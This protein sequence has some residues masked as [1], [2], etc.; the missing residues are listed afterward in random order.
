[1]ALSAIS[2]STIRR[3]TRAAPQAVSVACASCT[4]HREALSRKRSAIASSTRRFS[5][6][7]LQVA[8]GVRAACSNN[9][10]YECFAMSAEPPSFLSLSGVR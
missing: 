2:C 5:V 6:G 8:S 9:S 4:A 10:T 7:A 1:M 3:F